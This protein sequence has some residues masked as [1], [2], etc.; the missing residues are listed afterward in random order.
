MAIEE[1]GEITYGLRNIVL[2]RWTDNKIMDYVVVKLPA[3]V[4]DRLVLDI[5]AEI[6]SATMGYDLSGAGNSF[7]FAG[8][9]FERVDGQYWSVS[10][11]PLQRS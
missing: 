4:F 6:P 2:S 9:K 1:L 7:A 8:I 10:D 11:A 3:P 5:K